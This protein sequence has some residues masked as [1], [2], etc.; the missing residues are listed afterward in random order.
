MP[1]GPDPNPIFNP[2]IGEAITEVQAI[3][4]ST[5]APLKKKKKLI[6][7]LDSPA[8][9]QPLFTV[10]NEPGD[11]IPINFTLPYWNGVQWVHPVAGGAP[12]PSEI[13]ALSPATLNA[14]TPPYEWPTR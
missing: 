3:S 2:N 14:N 9:E 10:W 13:P 11:D 4:D 5:A 7:W 6:N 1:Q 8:A 12:T